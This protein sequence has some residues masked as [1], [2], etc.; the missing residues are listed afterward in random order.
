MEKLYDVAIIGGGPG[1]YVAAI[2]CGELGLSTVCIDA[3]QDASG[4]ARLGGTCLNV[5]CVPSKALLESSAHVETARHHLGAHGITVGEVSFDLAAMHARK[6]R[7]VDTLDNGI[8]TLFK[9]RKVTWLPGRARLATANG[10]LGVAVE[11]ADGV[12]NLRARHVI[13]AAGSRPVELPFLPFDH[14]RVVDSADALAFARVPEHLIVVGAGVIGLELGSVWRRLGARVTLLEAAQRFLPAADEQVAREA[15]RQL[16]AQGLDIRLGARVEAARVEKEGV[17]LT[18]QD[19]AGTQEITGDKVLVAVGRR[20]NS[21]GLGCREVGVAIDARGFIAVDDLC[22]TSVA[23]VWAI[24]DLVRGPMLAHK[25][26]DEGILVA[27]RIAGQ[28]GRVNYEA[29]PSV[30]YTHPEVAWVGAGEEALK[31]AQRPYRKAVYPFSA[32]A[33]ALAAEAGAG[34]VKLLADAETDRLLGVHVVG[35]NASELIAEAVLALE[36][37]AS[38]EDL[39]RT[40]HAHPTL[41]EALRDAAHALALR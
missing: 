34:F 20:P 24:G 27:E 14:A 28:A 36:Y 41:A 7:I 11:T 4:K 38:A 26:S 30:I 19:A 39:A 6:Q 16:Q 37:A 13:L 22:R 12:E 8:A 21:E 29:I 1:G 23:N 18:F 40:M 17:A 31:A 15:L 35:P 3:W 9:K 5:G 2:R 10:A 25:A 33:R 32:N